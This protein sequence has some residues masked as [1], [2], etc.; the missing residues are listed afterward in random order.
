MINQ[1]LE[2]EDCGNPATVKQYWDDDVDDAEFFCDTHVSEFWL[3]P[4]DGG[5]AVIHPRV[6]TVDIRIHT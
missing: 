6:S 1:Q 5:P 2:C 4:K 3:I